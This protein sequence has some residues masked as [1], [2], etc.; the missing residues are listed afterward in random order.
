LF[1]EKSLKKIKKEKKR[2]KLTEAK[3]IG[4]YKVFHVDSPAGNQ[5]FCTADGTT[6]SSATTGTAT[7]QTETTITGL[8][9]VYDRHK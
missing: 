3:Y 4:L 5:T 6:S 9:C 8:S 7:T 1:S 2:K